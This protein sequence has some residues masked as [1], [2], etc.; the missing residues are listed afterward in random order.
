MGGSPESRARESKR[1]AKPRGNGARATRNLAAKPLVDAA[2][3][4]L[5][6]FSPHFTRSSTTRFSLAFPPTKTASY[7]GYLGSIGFVVNYT[8]KVAILRLHSLCM[9]QGRGGGGQRIFFSAARFFISPPRSIQIFRTPPSNQPK[10]EYPP[11]P[12]HKK[13]QNKYLYNSKRHV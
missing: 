11:L 3:P 10:N 9:L 7:A 2:S 1:V 6:L 13:Y 12:P 5:S 4:R 8:I